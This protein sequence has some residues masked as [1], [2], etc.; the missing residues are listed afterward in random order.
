MPHGNIIRRMRV[1]GWVTKVKDTLRI[2]NTD[3]FSTVTIVMRTRLNVALQEHQFS[4]LHLVTVTT[5][6]SESL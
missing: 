3:C 2:C 1:A 4:C 6:P 5:E